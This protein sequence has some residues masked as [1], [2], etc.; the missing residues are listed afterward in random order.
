MLRWSTCW[1]RVA[2]FTPWKA[3]VLLRGYWWLGMVKPLSQTLH[4]WYIYCTMDSVAIK[5]YLDISNLHVDLWVHVL[6]CELSKFSVSYMFGRCKLWCRYSL[7]NW[8]KVQG[9]RTSMNLHWTYVFLWKLFFWSVDHRSLGYIQG[10]C[11][12]LCVIPQAGNKMSFAKAVTKQ[13][14]ASQKFLTGLRSLFRLGWE[15]F[16]AAE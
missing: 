15:H 13:L 9:F 1:F 7:I 10:L 8:L 16:A 12:R 4:V 14:L 5:T 3:R 11:Y 2:S 6:Y